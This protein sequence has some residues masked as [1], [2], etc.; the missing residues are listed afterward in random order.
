MHKSIHSLWSVEKWSHFEDFWEVLIVVVKYLAVVQCK[1]YS[2]STA[3]NATQRKTVIFTADIFIVYKN[4]NL[5]C[6]S[7]WAGWFIKRYW[8]KKMLE[9]KNRPKMHFLCFLRL[10]LHLEYKPRTYFPRDVAHYQADHVT[11]QLKDLPHILEADPPTY[12]ERKAGKFREN[13]RLLIGHVTRYP[14]P[15][16]VGLKGH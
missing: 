4:S 9:L 5:I 15:T 14:A 8:Q 11:N 1:K 6:D 16:L 7:F 3:G 12:R 2:E 13:L 10:H